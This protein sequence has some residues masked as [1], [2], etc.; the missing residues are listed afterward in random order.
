MGN[1]DENWDT[2]DDIRQG[3]MGMLDGAGIGNGA[4]AV[5]TVA[6]KAMPDGMGFEFMCQGCGRQRLLTLDY[7]ELVAIHFGLSP[8]VAFQRAPQFCQDPTQW[9]YRGHPENAWGLN[10]R[11]NRNCGYH[12]PVRMKGNECQQYLARA[13]KEGYINAAGEAAVVNH[14]RRVVA[15]GAP[16]Q[17]PA[18]MR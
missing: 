1:R 6:V 16:Q 7:A 11:C 5:D 15:A 18:R 17:G 12:Y 3:S 14:V 4:A 2:F 8:D 13:K 9:I 10:M